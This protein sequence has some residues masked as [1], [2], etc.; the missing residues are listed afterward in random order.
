[1]NSKK[2]LLRKYNFLKIFNLKTSLNK[3]IIN[4]NKLLKL[5]IIIKIVIIFKKKIIF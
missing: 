5:I 4:Y 1:M 3:N 2:L